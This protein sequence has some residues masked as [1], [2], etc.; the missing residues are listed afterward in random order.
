MKT[1]NFKVV[2]EPD[3]DRWHAYCPALKK[4][5]ASTWGNTQKE[6]VKHIQEVVQMIVD[7][8]IED[9]EKIPEEPKSE[10]EVLAEP[11]VG[12]TV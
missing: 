9:G 2:I 7:E 6:A 8:L 12:V 11:W 1:Y 3:D 10:V 4:Q 5:G